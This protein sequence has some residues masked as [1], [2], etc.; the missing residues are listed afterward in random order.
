MYVVENTLSLLA[1]SLC[2]HS[3][4]ICPYLMVN[5][6]GIRIHRFQ[7]KLKHSTTVNVSNHDTGT[8]VDME[9]LDSSTTSICDTLAISGTK[10][11]RFPH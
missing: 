11:M 10:K 4:A 7:D 5:S 8:D 3:L 9:K 6:T 1:V 2:G